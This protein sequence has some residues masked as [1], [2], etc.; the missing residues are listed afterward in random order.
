LNSTVKHLF[1]L[2]N[3]CPDLTALKIGERSISY[4]EL[5]EKSMLVANGLIECGAINETIGLVGQRKASSYIGILGILFAGCN[6]TPINPKYNVARIRSI[7]NNSKIRFLVG[8]NEDINKLELWNLPDVDACI[9]PEGDSLKNSSLRVLVASTLSNLG[10]L[11]VPQVNELTDLA[12]IN[13]TSGSTGTPKGVMVSHSNLVSF[14]KNMKKI[15]S[16]EPGF[17]ASQA[18]D[19]SFDPSVSD[20]FFTWANKGVLCVLPESEIMVPTDFIIRE[21]ITYWNSVPSIARFMLNTGNLTPNSFPELKNSMFCG[22]QFP[23]DLA[24]AWRLAAPNSTIENLYGPTEATVYISRYE[25]SKDDENKRFHNGIVPIGSVYPGHTVKLLN[26]EG[27][28]VESGKG[29]IV[30]SGP[31]VTLGYLNDQHKTDES[32][33]NFDWDEKSRQ[34]YKTGDL[35]FFNESGNLECIGRKDSQIK[36]AGRRIEIGEIEA[37]LDKFDK[38]KGVIIVPTRND[39]EIVNGCVGFLQVDISHAEIKE[40]RKQSSKFLDS[41]FFPKKFYKIKE[42]PL[43]QSGKTNR[44]ELEIIAKNLDN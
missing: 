14:L 20:I 37:M 22:E 6:F 39:Q 3:S 19:F 9:L 23:V 11:S 32:F 7:F 21:K 43:T 27:Q 44:K 29:E 12:Y 40:I 24:N 42:I 28:I 17:K 26:E 35:G 8:E 18:F 1:D 4:A 16:L 5:I 10:H 36:L 41:V 25:Y 38:T 30:F 31:Q 13:Y 2:K 15:Y 33:V 34:W